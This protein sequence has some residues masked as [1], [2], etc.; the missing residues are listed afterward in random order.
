MLMKNLLFILSILAYQ[1][2]M[3]QDTSFIYTYGGLSYDQGRSVQQ[4][5]DGG[6]ILAGS[7]GSFGLGNS[8]MYLVKVD[9]SGNYL[10]S[11]SYGG[12]F[13]DVGMHVEQTPDKGYIF[14]GYT[15][16]YGAGGYDIY[17]VKTDSIGDTLWT[18]TYGG[19]NWE[20]GHELV[21][22]FDGGFAIIGETFSYGA[23]GSDVYL[24]KTDISGDSLWTK[25]YGGLADDFGR[26]IKETLDS[27][28]IIAG[29]TESY[30]L[31]KGDAYL[32]KTDSTGDTSWTHVYGGAEMDFAASVI[33]TL[34]SNY[35]FTGT[36]KSYNVGNKDIYFVIVNDTGAVLFD[37]Y[38]GGLADDDEGYQLVQQNPNRYLLLGYTKSFGAGEKDFYLFR[39]DKNG[40]WLG[41]GTSPTFGYPFD[42]EGF[43]IA[44]RSGGGLA[45]LG[46]T[47]SIGTGLTDML[48]IIT[49]SIGADYNGNAIGISTPVSSFNDTNIA[50]VLISIDDIKSMGTAATIYP[51][52]TNGPAFINIIGNDIADYDVRVTLSD[53]SGKQLGISQEIIA[54]PYL[55]S[56]ET[57]SNGIYI[58]QISLISKSASK[59]NKFYRG[60]LILV[61][62]KE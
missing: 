48:L 4:T 26:S 6:Y 59:R 21:Q 61:K 50:T 11:R 13:T 56:T 25:T 31:G 33:Q 1:N 20:I 12:S 14:L 55:I 16:S 22:T 17:L 23:G 28:F 29:G 40:Y 44:L 60:K 57:L 10:W 2:T 45:L 37:H 5:S 47:R 24:I 32:I 49:D 8:D 39:G 46:N 27:G 38:H 62:E 34:D 43:S 18:K 58:Y 15:D 7:T 19:L 53:M 35:A 3:G 51:N 30:D 9:S 54:F 42:D 52:P 36:T 41:P